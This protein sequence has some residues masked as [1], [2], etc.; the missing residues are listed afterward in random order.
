[1]TADERRLRFDMRRVIPAPRSSVFRA[2]T[3]PAELAKWWGPRGF[4][5]P[6]VEIDLRPGGGYRIEMQPPETDAF[7]LAGEF[8]E[9]DPPA[10]LAYTFRWEDP[11]PDDRETVVRLSLRD[12]GDSTEL[13]V[14]QGAFA[15][16]P[17]LALH[18]EGWADT[19]DRLH[20]LLSS[21]SATED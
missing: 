1:M 16:E 8:L 12:L 15:T 21:S 20:G 7:Y 11:D 10:G 14:S 6:S 4:T 17:R 2:C 3:E 18:E 19:L 5:A 9:I 13:I